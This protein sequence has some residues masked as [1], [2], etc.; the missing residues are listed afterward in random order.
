MTILWVES[1]DEAVA[2][3]ASDPFVIHGLRTFEIRKWMMMEGSL[4]LRVRF[5]NRSIEVE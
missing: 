2:I 4:S 1:E 3:A 5:S